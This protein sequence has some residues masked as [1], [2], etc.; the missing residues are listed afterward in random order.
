MPS[1][2]AVTL[3]AGEPLRLQLKEVEQSVNGVRAVMHHLDMIHDKPV[4][5]P[6]QTVFYKSLWLRADQ[7]GVLLSE[8]APLQRRAP[9]TPGL[10]IR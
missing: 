10:I 4:R 6:K 2:A 7:S 1:L 8:V 3:E 9:P 5:A